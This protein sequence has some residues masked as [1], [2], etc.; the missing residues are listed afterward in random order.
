[1][2]TRSTI[3][4]FG[5]LL[6]AAVVFVVAGCSDDDA[7][8]T[9]N[10]SPGSVSDPQ[11]LL[12]QGQINEYLDSTQSVFSVGLKNISQLPTDTEEVVIIHNAM[13]PNDTAQYT[14]ANG[15]HVTYIAKYTQYYDVH[16]RDS[17]QFMNDDV[18]V[19]TPDPLDYLHFI[20]YWELTSNLTSQTHTNLAQY[21]NLTYDNL[22]TDTASIN[23]TSNSDVEWNFIS[24]DTT[25][26]AVFNMN[27]TV[28]NIKV[29][30]SNLYGW[31]SGCPCSGTISMT[32]I[33]EYS[34]TM[35]A[36]QVDISRN[37]SITIDIENGVASVDIVSETETWS[38]TYIICSLG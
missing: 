6:L 28:E 33:E 11:F 20:R 8:S 5:L 19:E 12:I 29:A 13:G 24:G 25:V 18:V 22:D 34:A 37:W 23:G 4:G 14:Y 26:T 30:R 10:L 35:G 21:I 38:Y 17:V 15:W 16:F 27:V 31:V 36:D 32:I 3:P 9:S 2:H 1:M 7:P